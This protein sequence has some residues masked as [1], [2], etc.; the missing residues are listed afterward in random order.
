[1]HLFK[2]KLQVLTHSGSFHADELFACATLLL[3]AEKNNCR[4]EITRSRDEAALKGADIVV[5]VGMLYDQAKNRF[6]HHQRGGAGVRKSGV[7]YASFGLVWLKYGKEVCSDEEVAARIEK[8]LVVPID[9]RDNGVNISRMTELGIHDHR[10]SD[11][12]CNFNPTAQESGKSVDEQ[13]KKALDFAFEILKR[14]IAWAKAWSDGKKEALKEIEKQQN[15]EILIL[16]KNIEWHEAV[17]ENK[18]IKFVIY[19]HRNGKHWCVECGKN[20]LEDYDSDRANLPQKWWSL[21][22]EELQEATGISDTLFCAN[23]GWFGTAESKEG[24]LEM[25]KKSLQVGS[26]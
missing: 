5:D 7:P 20:D 19:P 14:E 21:K 8:D 13:F 6:D 16:D 11:M 12:I 9:A 26:N 2:T 10:T 23:R 18:S 4:L 17:S 15:P 22:G 25:A 1:M 3:W 24:V